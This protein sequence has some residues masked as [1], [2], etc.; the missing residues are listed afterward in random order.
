[1][2]RIV[3]RMGITMIAV[4]LA[5]TAAAARAQGVAPSRDEQL[6]E[7]KKLDFMPGEWRGKAV[8]QLR[9]KE[10]TVDMV[11]KIEA[12]LD[13]LAIVIDGRGTVPDADGKART[14]HLAVGLINWDAEAHK[15]RFI[16]Q[17]EKGYYTVADA[18]FADGALVW[19]FK[20]PAG[21]TRFR[22]RLNEK[23]QWRES[24]EFSRDEQTWSP[25][26]E[27]TLDKVK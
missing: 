22:I 20:T 2:M 6:R 24:G 5:F 18:N 10:T 8:H 21:S 7:M 9:G 4:A 19:S 12:R 27:M 16:A 3:G 1:M 23:G 11:E 14:G 26:F 13:G 17:T 15:Y 25:F